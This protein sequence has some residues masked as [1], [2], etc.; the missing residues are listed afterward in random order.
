MAGNLNMAGSNKSSKSKENYHF[1]THLKAAENPPQLKAAIVKILEVLELDSFSFA[2]VGVKNPK[3]LSNWPGEL[4]HALAE[5]A[6]HDLITKHAETEIWPVYLSDIVDYIERSPLVLESNAQFLALA[7]VAAEYGLFDS[8]NI[9]YATPMGINCLFAASK[10]NMAAADF[11]ARVEDGR[12]LLYLLGDL[13][14]NIA[15]A[16][17]SPYFLGSRAFSKVATLTPKQLQLLEW[18]AKHNGTLKNAA[19]AMYISLDTANKR[20]AA[21]KAALGAKTQAAAVYRGI[22]AGLIEIDGWEWE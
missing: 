3:R 1:Y 6:E 7:K 22:V 4:Q 19:D 9:P 10:L 14:A 12:D 16:R 15:M 17:H 13:V 8:Y 18:L 11:R 5:H 2:P 20:V 21:I